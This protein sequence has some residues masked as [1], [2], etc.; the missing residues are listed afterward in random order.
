VLNLVQFL[1]YG[2]MAVQWTCDCRQGHGLLFTIA[3][4]PAVAFT[5]HPGQLDTK[6]PLPTSKA[7]GPEADHYTHLVATFKNQ[8][9]NIAPPPYVLLTWCVVEQSDLTRASTEHHPW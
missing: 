9:N 1:T 3:S 5:Q 6:D 8:L 2:V 7:A 4:R